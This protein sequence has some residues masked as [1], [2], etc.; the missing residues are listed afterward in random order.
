MNA[1]ETRNEKSDPLPL[2]TLSSYVQ[3]ALWASTLFH[4][5]E[6]R[7]LCWGST[8][9]SK[10]HWIAWLPCPYWMELCFMIQYLKHNSC[11]SANQLP[12][13]VTNT[14]NS[15]SQFPTSLA[16]GHVL[17][18]YESSENDC[19]GWE[20]KFPRVALNTW[21]D[22]SHYTTISALLVCWSLDIEGRHLP[23]SS[24]P[25][26]NRTSQCISCDLCRKLQCPTLLKSWYVLMIMS[27]FDSCAGMG[28]LYWDGSCEYAC[29][30]LELE[31]RLNIFAF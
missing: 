10:M 28:A 6:P 5:V 25:G 11:L 24:S 13:N 7:G 16:G 1:T 23:R 15:W 18:V 8:M 30:F 27:D 20:A 17:L 9:S 29:L 31:H 26:Y 19:V 22:M 3:N 21:P 14:G 2:T 4:W 12:L